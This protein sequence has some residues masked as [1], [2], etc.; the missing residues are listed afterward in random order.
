MH[1]LHGRNRTDLWL[2]TILL[3]R[4]WVSFLLDSESVNYLL[5]KLYTE[6]TNDEKRHS[7]LSRQNA[8]SRRTSDLGMRKFFVTLRCTQS[9]KSEHIRSADAQFTT[10]FHRHRFQSPDDIR[11]RL[12]VKWYIF[13]FVY[14]S[15]FNFKV[16]ENFLRKQTKSLKQ[17][18]FSSF[19]IVRHFRENGRVCSFTFSLK[20]LQSS[21]AKESKYIQNNFTG[22]LLQR[23]LAVPLWAILC[24]RFRIIWC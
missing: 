6:K 18:L 16:S 8:C 4:H 22:P 9:S 24:Q 14:S 23:N 10:E 7:Y 5:R 12:C 20:F 17:R 21:F 1:V 15:A 3:G 11:R 2:Q 19:Y 13:R